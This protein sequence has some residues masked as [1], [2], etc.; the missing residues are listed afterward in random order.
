[1]KMNYKSNVKGMK[2]YKKGI[3]EKYDWIGIM[4]NQLMKLLMREKEM[5]MA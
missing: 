1:M 3:I 2:G 4:Y 5:T